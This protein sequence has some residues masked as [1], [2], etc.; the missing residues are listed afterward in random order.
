MASLRNI[1]VGS[2][3]VETAEE[4]RR[5]GREKA[6]ESAKKLVLRVKV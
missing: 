6:R 1:T 3:T 4:A 5:L 2:K